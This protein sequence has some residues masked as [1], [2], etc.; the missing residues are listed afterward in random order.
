MVKFQSPS[1]NTLWDLNYFLVICSYVTSRQKAMHKSPP[2]ICT[3]GL[4]NIMV[5]LSCYQ[6]GISLGWVPSCATWTSA[7]QRKY[8]FGTLYW[9]WPGAQQSLVQ[10]EP[11]TC[12]SAWTCPLIQVISQTGYTRR[13]CLPPPG[14]QGCYQ[15]MLIRSPQYNILTR[16]FS[17]LGTGRSQVGLYSMYSVLWP[18][19]HVELLGQYWLG[20]NNT[21]QYTHSVVPW[22][23]LVDH[24]SHT[25]PGL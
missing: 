17:I 24:R 20:Q 12:P 6:S 2:C 10:V 18:R 15:N 7:V 9:F 19:G 14:G 16:R 11:S 3:G 22:L 23:G 5:I 4:N 21:I 13:H 1:Y 25:Q 8:K